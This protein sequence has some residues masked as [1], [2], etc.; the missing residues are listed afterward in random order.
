L[1]LEHVRDGLRRLDTG[2]LDAFDVDES[3]QRYK[4]S[5]RE[6]WKFCGQTDRDMLLRGADTRVLAHSG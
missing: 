5:A 6:L 3:I 4:R 2:E 1:L